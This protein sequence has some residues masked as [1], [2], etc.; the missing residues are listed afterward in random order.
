VPDSIDNCRN[1]ANPN[2]SDADYDNIGN[3]CDNCEYFNPGQK[4]KNNNNV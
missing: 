2:Q 3:V 4:D 1:V